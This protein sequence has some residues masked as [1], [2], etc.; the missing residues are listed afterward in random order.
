VTG[1]Y[2]LLW[3]GFL[4][5]VAHWESSRQETNRPEI[6]GLRNASLEMTG[7][8]AMVIHGGRKL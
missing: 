4:S 6:S 3:D 5:G 2:F 8:S 1:G 7:R